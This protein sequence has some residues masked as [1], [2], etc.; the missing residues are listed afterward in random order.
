MSEQHTPDMLEALRA[1]ERLTDYIRQ[2]R[3]FLDEDILDEWAGEVSPTL[4]AA[5]AAAPDMLGTVTGAP[6]MWAALAEERKENLRLR[7]VIDAA[8]DM[9]AALLRWRAALENI[10][11][12]ENV[13][14]YD[15]LPWEAT[16]AAIA[17]ATEEASS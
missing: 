7:R 3:G 2:H 1:A 12:S 14:E 17:A 15:A 13:I 8:P 6:F 10:D 16:D 9:L 4:A 11:F 5:I